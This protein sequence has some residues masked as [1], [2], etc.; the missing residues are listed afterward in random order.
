LK[1]E[2]YKVADHTDLIKNSDSKAVLNTNARSL[3]KYREE[4]EKLM[5]LYRVVEDTDR[6]KEDVADI[7]SML[8]QLLENKK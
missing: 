1:P 4:R 7:K 8:R 2:F 3:D 5:K 6:L